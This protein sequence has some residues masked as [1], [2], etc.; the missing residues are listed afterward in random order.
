MPNSDTKTSF[1]KTLSFGLPSL[2]GFFKTKFLRLPEVNGRLRVLF[3]G[4]SAFG[5]PALQAL[6][7]E[8]HI[9][10]IGVITQPDKAAG[11]KQLLNPPPIKVEAERYHLSILQ[12]D[13]IKNYASEIKKLRP[14]LIVV[15]AYG[16]IIP[17]EIL[18][19]PK[20]GCL[21]VHGSILPK[22]RGAAVLQAPILN[23]DKQSGVT[24]MKMD[25]GLDTGPIIS[26]A[27]L[28]LEPAETPVTLATKLSRLGADLL[29]PTIRKYVSGELKPQPQ[30]NELASYVSML[31][32][33]DGKI[34]WTR[35]AVEVE[36][37]IRGLTPWPGAWTNWNGKTLKIIEV[38][39]EPH[40]I[41]QYREGEVFL[42]HDKLAVQCAIDAL[43]IKRL[44][45]EGKT[46]TTAEE[47]IRGHRDIIH[48][49]L[50]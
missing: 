24:I 1:V 36:R 13:R 27:V 23:G 34:D 29:I 2:Q 12:P 11:R 16:Q 41:E 39:H 21:N 25:K 20:Y 19:I 18:N 10:V 48:S 5:I 45:L 26:Q 6:M 22:Y 32:K 14:G 9:K 17:E 33:K 8:P 47:F 38:E 44:Q 3:I 43:I 49:V 28:E 15:V 37:Q 50:T 35:T 40:R 31:D 4:T 46:E 7:N 42:D 30:N